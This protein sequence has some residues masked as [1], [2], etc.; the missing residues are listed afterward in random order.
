MDELAV[1]GN[2]HRP[3]FVD[4]AVT[5]GRVGHVEVRVF[6][7]DDVDA[8]AG[9]V[10][11]QIGLAVAAREVHDDAGIGDD[12]DAVRRDF[13]L[14]HLTTTDLEVQRHILRAVRAVAE[15]QP[16]QLGV[17]V[18]GGTRRVVLPRTPVH[19]SALRLVGQPGPAALDRRVGGHG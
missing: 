11:R 4:M 18:D 15:R 1:V 2:P 7:G 3:T 10:A 13:G 14:D 6:L 17:D 16:I 9:D 12:L 5:G 19:A 8:V